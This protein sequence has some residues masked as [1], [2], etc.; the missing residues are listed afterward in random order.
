MNIALL[1]SACNPPHLGHVWIARQVLDYEG[2]D[3]V[4]M[5]PT[6]HHN[7]DKAM[8]E[9]DHRVAMAKM[10]ETEK[11]KVSMIEIENKLDGQTI[12]ILP[13]LPKGNTYQFII[14]SDQLPLFHKWGEYKKLVQQMKFLVFP[15]YGH[16]IEPLYENMSVMKHKDL[17]TSSISST[18]VRN[19]IEAGRS[20]VDFVPSSIASYIHTHNLYLP[21]P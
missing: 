11:I 16:P 1:G 12:N 6:Y 20:I 14:G 10:L 18:V 13:F 8:I 2:V 5:L 7:F 4:W 17:V 9:V 19:R 21:R 3:E 15:R